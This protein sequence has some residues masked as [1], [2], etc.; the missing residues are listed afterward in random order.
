[1]VLAARRWSGPTSSG[2][3][4][5]TSAAVARMDVLAGCEGGQ[6]GRLVGQVRQ[7]PQLDLRVVGGH[8]Q[9]PGLGHERLAHGTAEPAAHRDVLQVGIGRGEP[10][11]GSHRLVEAGVDAAVGG[12]L[13]R[14]GVHVGRLELGLL[15]VLQDEGGQAEA[16]RRQLL[17]DVR[18]GGR[19][20]GLGGAAHH[21]QPAA[22]EEHLGQL[23]RRVDVEG[24]ARFRVD[25]ALEAGQGGLQASGEVREHR[26]LQPDARALHR[27]EHRHQGHLD[28]REDLLEA[29]PAQRGV[30]QRTEL[31]H[32]PGGFRHAYVGRRDDLVPPRQG[33][34]LHGLPGS[35]Q[36]ARQ[37]GVPGHTADLGPGIA[38]APEQRLGVVAPDVVQG[39]GQRWRHIGSVRAPHQ[40]LSGQR[41]RELRRRPTPRRRPGPCPEPLAPPPGSPPGWGPPS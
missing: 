9:V 28:V 10:P 19:R 23:L 6:Q 27:L 14:Q 31:P 33:D 39:R 13:P 36:V 20:L 18:V 22:G 12:H 24:T 8:Q 40:H 16:A 7:H 15:A 17:E 41:E 3:T 35:Q 38:Q 37:H 4:P 26:R 29:L 21:R 1:M 11:G 34:Q 5:K 30:Q 32:R 25:V 2:A